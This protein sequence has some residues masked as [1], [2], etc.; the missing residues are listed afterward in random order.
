MSTS[1]ALPVR[2][3]APPWPL[4][5]P[6]AAVPAPLLFVVNDAHPLALLGGCVAAVMF[7]AIPFAG[8]GGSW[9]RAA[10]AVLAFAVAVAVV[11]AWRTLALVDVPPP[12]ERQ[13]WLVLAGPWV[14]WVYT[15]AR[16]PHRRTRIP[17]PAKAP[18]VTSKRV[19]LTRLPVAKKT[20]GGRWSLPFAGSH[21]LVVGAT[22]SGKGSVIWSSVKALAP[23]ISAG[24]VQ[25]TAI[26]PKGG[27]ELG[28][29]E[30]LF[31]AHEYGE[32]D[33]WQQRI[34][35]SLDEHVALMQARAGRMRKVGSRKHAP[36]VEEPLQVLIIDELL[37][38]TAMVN[39]SELRRQI[40]NALLMLLSQGRAPGWVVMAATQ[41]PSKEL[42]DTVR[43]F[44]PTRVCLR[45][46]D[47][48]HVD[49]AL[50]QGARDRG[51]ASDKVA[52]RTPGRGFV[53]DEGSEGMVEV[54][55][56]WVSD[57]DIRALCQRFPAPGAA[58]YLAAEDAAPALA[59]SAVAEAGV[60][61]YDSA[62]QPEAGGAS[63]LAEVAGVIGECPG[64]SWDELVEAL[65]VDREDLQDRLRRVGVKSAP[66]RPPGSAAV[67]RGVRRSDVEA[68]IASADGE[69]V[70]PLPGV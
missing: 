27:M 13:V 30:P 61:I 4:L 33:G 42:L 57:D 38:L 12:A 7:L 26:D 60:S 19:D 25:I 8:V 24:L 39:D 14:L 45:V 55:F 59:A 41:A 22:G 31:H 32:G 34:A 35:A 67:V 16:M 49:M 17:T 54:Q 2:Q 3:W 69:C 20:E 58:P 51:A 9:T 43:E 1:T 29:G 66:F 6:L 11:A 46:V 62:V 70:T 64:A 50:G 23:H 48:R 10:M 44:F 63:V 5:V 56:D 21:V 37:A 47:W 15:V 36:T 68:A 18:R 52:L 65:D 40:K 53:F 28:V